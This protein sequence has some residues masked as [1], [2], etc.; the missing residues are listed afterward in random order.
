MMKINL[1]SCCFAKLN[2]P[3]MNPVHLLSLILVALSINSIAIPYSVDPFTTEFKDDSRRIHPSGFEENLGQVRNTV[4]DAAPFVR[5]RLV[6]GNTSIFLLN[7]GIAFQFSRIHYPNG[8][9][10]S[11]RDNYRE[12]SKGYELNNLMEEVRTE[13][14]RMDMQLKGANPSPVISTKGRSLDF[15]NYYSHNVF[16]LHTYTTVTYHDVYPGID[17]VVYTNEGGLKYD[18]VVHP[19]ADPGM[20]NLQFTD[21]EE[22]R[23]ASDGSLV[24][25]NSLG[26][27]I[28]KA[29][30]SYQGDKKVPTHFVLNGTSLT[31]W[32]A[33]YD[34]SITLVIDPAR[35]WGSYYGGAEYTNG[36]ACSTDSIGNVYLAGGTTSTAAIAS[37]GHQSYF[38]GDFDAFLVKF[39]S[40]GSRLWG[41]YYGG[42]GFDFGFSCPTDGYGN[43]FL[44]GGTSS[45]TNMASG[46]YQNTIG[47]NGDAFLVKFDSSGN[48]LWGSYIGGANWDYGYSSSTDS[49]GNVYLAGTTMSTYGIVSGGHQSTHGGNEDSFLVKFGPN[50]DYLWGTYY[51][52]A[53][54][55]RGYT[56]S[57]D[58]NG[59]VYLAGSTG[60]ISAIA[61]GGHQS[62][63]GGNGDAFLVKFDSLGNHVWSTYYGGEDY[64]SGRTC[65]SDASGNVYLAGWTQSNSG[66]ASGGHQNSYGGGDYNTFLV[67]FDSNGNRLWGTYYGGGPQI[68]NNSCTTDASGNVYLAGTTNSE[69]TIASDGFQNIYGGG[70]YDAFIVKFDSIGN[71]L[72][73]TYYGGSDDDA[74]SDCATDFY[75]NVFLSG[76]TRSTTAIASGGHQ[77]TFGGG[78]RDGFL[79]KFDGG[80]DVGIEETPYLTINTFP[81]PT[82]GT[83]TINASET[84]LR[85]SI[86][87]ANGRILRKGLLTSPKTLL[88]LSAEPAGVYLLVTHK[89][90]RS[91][92]VRFVKR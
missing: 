27:F 18:F 73:G 82:L 46:G 59:N 31:F 54:G 88:N 74:G 66:I 15:T 30:I 17:W 63:F 13:T 47:G 23:L 60:S 4:G 55:D 35:I 3:T 67:K 39:N 64:D 44:S 85:Y 33:D 81:N 84:E 25:G 38:G 49:Y 52:G 92:T 36:Y 69:N 32:L 12:P 72:W 43:V 57:T 80:I 77:N 90:G 89:D 86:I 1:T 6:Q 70:E 40:N 22:L 14:F 26:R 9:S 53:S 24:H 34:P 91:Q 65:S 56:C 61:N 87:D 10:Q 42:E 16:D 21:H 2:T 48:R 8:W 78:N 28:E 5:Y 41:T 20:I 45:S 83:F 58:G 29:P 76:F 68:D 37:N 7:N 51:G 71:R 75:G 11:V 79:V 50:G 62:T 19:G